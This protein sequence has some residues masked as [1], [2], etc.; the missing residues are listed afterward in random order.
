[1]II[2]AWKSRSSLG[3]RWKDGMDTD[4]NMFVLRNCWMIP[5]DHERWRTLLEEAKTQKCYFYPG[6][7]TDFLHLPK[8]PLS[9]Q[10]IQR[11]I[12]IKETT[13]HIQIHNIRKNFE[14]YWT[15][16]YCW[17]VSQFHILRFHKSRPWVTSHCQMCV[18]GWSWPSALLT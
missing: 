1:M 17:H 4:G 2:R 12:E 8:I 11:Q 10:Q 3:W 7:S 15:Y 13:H 5:Q 14:F 18:Q 6:V 16:Q 9:L